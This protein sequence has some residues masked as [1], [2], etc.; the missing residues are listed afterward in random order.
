VRQFFELQDFAQTPRSR[1][2]FRG[3][4]AC[5]GPSCDDHG[6]QARRSC[7]LKEAGKAPLLLGLQE[8]KLGKIA[9]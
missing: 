3:L 2:R 5:R 1:K 7:A 4:Q 8:S 9:R 6:Q